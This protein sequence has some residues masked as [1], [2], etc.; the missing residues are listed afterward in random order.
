[1]KKIFI[2]IIAMLTCTLFAV[3]CDQTEKPD[4]DTASEIQSETQSESDTQED[5]APETNEGS[6]GVSEGETKAET[7][8][9][10]KDTISAEC[11]VKKGNRYV[12]VLPAS[13]HSIPVDRDF[14]K[15]LPYVS[16][17]LVAAAEA[18]ITKEVEEIGGELGWTIAEHENGKMC[19]VV[20]V[21]KFVEGADYMEEVGC[22]IDHH[23]IFFAE[24][25]IEE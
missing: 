4:K 11:V 6:E 25:I 22:G 21:I 5:K 13:Q 17:E 18:K 15:Y 19:L 2:L 3:G 20:E 9:S 23:H 12:I 10:K 24:P 16:D 7:E 14:T 8:T 1:M